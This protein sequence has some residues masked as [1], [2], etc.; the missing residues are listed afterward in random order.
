MDTIADAKA[1]AKELLNEVLACNETSLQ[2]KKYLYLHEHLERCLLKLDDVLVP[3]LRPH[4]KAAVEL[5]EKCLDILKRKVEL[6]YDI[7]QIAAK[8]S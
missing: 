1:G 5:V 2:S 3:E 8:S 6:N 4:R 7:Q